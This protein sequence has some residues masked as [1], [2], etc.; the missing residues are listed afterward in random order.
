MQH[1]CVPGIQHDIVRFLLA[2]A[3][4]QTFIR[5]HTHTHTHTHSHTHTRTH[6]RRHT[7]TH[8][9]THRSNPSQREMLMAS[10]EE[11]LYCLC[12]RLEDKLW[13]KI[14]AGQT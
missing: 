4:L 13:N 3:Y 11:S 2:K 12:D 5:T 6:A 10:L 14:D 8:T 9:H 7:H 1:V